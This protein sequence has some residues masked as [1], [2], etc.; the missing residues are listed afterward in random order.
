MTVTVDVDV[1]AIR[2]DPSAASGSL[3]SGVDL[4]VAVD[5]EI[6]TGVRR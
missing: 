2:C 6:G 3:E 1:E 5:V 4:S